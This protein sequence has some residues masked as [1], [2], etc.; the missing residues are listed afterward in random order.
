MKGGDPMS[1][2]KQTQN[3]KSGVNPVAAG[4]AGAI[5]GAGVAVA[6]TAAMKDEKTR[7]QVKKVLHKVKNQASEYMNDR[8][9]KQMLEEGKK[10]VKNAL[11]SGE[12]HDAKM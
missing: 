7:E 3:K 2:T 10:H 1:D 5:V 6:A 8:K 4:V 9:T 12:Q 11:H